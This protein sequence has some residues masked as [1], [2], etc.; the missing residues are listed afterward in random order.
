[1]NQDQIK[2][3]CFMNSNPVWGGGE[4]FVLDHA[5]RCIEA[6]Y[7]VH[8][9]A[10]RDSALAQR[11]AAERGLTL[12]TM[13]L[14]NLSFLNPL[15]RR[16]LVRLF[17]SMNPES[18]ALVMALPSD[19]KAGGLAARAAGV[20]RIVF[21]RGIAVPVRDTA[22][23]RHL[24]G[25]VMDRLIVNSGETRRC[26]LANNP[27]LIPSDRIHLAY[28]GFDVE[29]FDAMEAAPLRPRTDEAVIIGCA[30][31]LTR[32]KG[33]RHLLQAMAIL[34]DRGRDVRLLLAGEGSD[35][36]TLMALAAGLE[37]EDRIEFLGFVEDTKRFYASLDIV[38]LPS[39]WEGFGYA[40]VE[41]MTMRLPVV[42]FNTSSIPE[43]VE[44]GVTGL[45]AEPGDT[46]ELA[47]CLERLVAD[48]GL[49]RQL[50]KAG[51][52]R[53]LDR[54]H[55]DKAFADFLVAVTHRPIP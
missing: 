54:F 33:Q 18:L 38:A 7:A 48:P 2:T 14:G 52:Q 22:L 11:A 29:A 37:I 28:N 39:L 55:T 24:Y 27:R 53:V 20:R 46:A 43:V 45:L 25:K 15:K 3:I 44:D 40:L 35:R 4:K 31:R 10:N 47:E 32:Q 6:G 1:M 13:R 8:V 17:C 26:V 42:A 34:L 9:L 19:L 41:A 16:T 5:R 30:A 21:R 50:G 36:E 12:H 49:R 51:R 23:N